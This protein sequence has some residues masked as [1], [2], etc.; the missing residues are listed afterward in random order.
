MSSK[1]ASLL[2]PR[3]SLSSLNL[4]SSSPSS[5]SIL[6]FV[7]YINDKIETDNKQ[8]FDHKGLEVN[9][10]NQE[11]GSGSVKTSSSNLG[12]YVVTRR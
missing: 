1:F 7:D 3:W 11:G 10:M 8:K 4:K 6:K 5:S 9:R 2:K 12:G